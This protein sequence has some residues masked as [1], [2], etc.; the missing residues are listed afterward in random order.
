MKRIRLNRLQIV[1]RSLQRYILDR[2]LMH[3]GKSIGPRIDPWVTPCSMKRKSDNL[4][5]HSTFL[6]PSE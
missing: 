6:L 5:L 2:S 4:P 3:G 1:K